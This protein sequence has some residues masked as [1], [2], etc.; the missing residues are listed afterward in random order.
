[1][2]ETHSSAG[3]RKTAME[4]GAGIK[5][6]ALHGNNALNYTDDHFKEQS[7]VWNALAWARVALCDASIANMFYLEAD[8]SSKKIFITKLGPVP[9]PKDPY[10][11]PLQVAKERTKQVQIQTPKSVSN[12]MKRRG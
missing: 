11:S 8:H 3:Q 6:A 12:I 7:D 1:M 5:E 4:Y 9:S 10:E 2:A